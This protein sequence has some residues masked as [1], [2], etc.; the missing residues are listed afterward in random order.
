MVTGRVPRRVALYLA[1]AALLSLNGCSV[2]C[3]FR[4]AVKLEPMSTETNVARKRG[5][6]LVQQELSTATREATRVAGL[7]G[8]PCA[9]PS[10]ACI[11]NLAGAQGID[12]S[13]RLA[14]L[15]ELWRA[16][17]LTLRGDARL[18]AWFEVARY[19]Y[20]YLLFAESDANSGA[21]EMR[22]VQV[23]DT[24]N[25]A[26]QQVA[27][28]MFASLS[29]NDADLRGREL[30]RVGWTLRVSAPGVRASGQPSTAHELLPAAAMSFR[31]LRSIYRREGVGAELVAVMDRESAPEQVHDR[32]PEA[33]TSRITSQVWS[34]M[35]APPITVLLHFEGQDLD[36]VLTTHEATFS[37][38]DPYREASATLGRRSL[39]LAAN[40]TAGYGLWLARSG[41]SGQSLST[42]F[43]HGARGIKRPHVYLMQ[44]YDPQRRI[45]VMLHGLASSPEAWVDLANEILGDEVLRQQYQVWQVY[46]PTNIPTALS[47][48][49]IRDALT[50]TLA[51]FDPT[52]QAPAS[53]DLVVIGH[54]LGGIIARLMVSSAGQEISNLITVQDI[55]GEQ[56]ER[57]DRILKRL[58]TVVHFGPLPGVTRAI[59]IATPH[60]GTP[61]AGRRPARWLSSLIRLP[62]TLMADLAAVAR[63]ANRDIAKIRLPN[64][65][66]NLDENDPFVRAVADLPISPVVR[67]HS[68]IA[69]SDPATP[70]ADSDDGLVPYRSAHLPDAESELVIL[71]GHRV[72]NSVPATTEIRRILYEA[73]KPTQNASVKQPDILWQR[74]R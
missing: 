29:R 69:R 52:G 4:P 47:H 55:P 26:V 61:S 8:G 44:P 5:D 48:A 46:Y 13:R 72:Q 70:L 67:Y 66:D 22:H 7:D 40:F 57:R 53:R 71:S 33:S 56:R 14:A 25:H 58:D 42:F 12:E 35:P 32:Q 11:E 18:E 43:G 34:E 20:A 17:A 28:Q 1:A 31:G 30:H 41:F 62:G 65:I 74:A 45:I 73:A 9:Q 59:F 50:Q 51:Q 68:I 54:S 36:A 63:D 6:M 2:W 3:E 21:F 37:V 39:P 27:T 64:S 16:H 10:R 19:A 15:S 24:Y 49:A 38:H 23:R 60:R